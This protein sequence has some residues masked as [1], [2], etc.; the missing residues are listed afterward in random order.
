M[1]TKDDKTNQ[2]LR[3][4]I[5]SVKNYLHLARDQGLTT[6]DA[7][8]EVVDNSVDADARNVHVT[9]RKQDA[10]HFM[11]AVEDD[12][13][14]IPERIKDGDGEEW[15]GIAYC[16]SLGGRGPK[17][18]QTTIGKF[19]A[20]LTNAACCQSIVTEIYT[21]TAS[22]NRTRYN[23]MDLNRMEETDDLRM[24][25]ME[26]RE[27]P[28]H[29]TTH[30][31]AHRTGTLVV[32]AKVDNPDYKTESKLIS[33]IEEH[34]ALVYFKFIN[35]GTKIFVNGKELAPYDPTWRTPGGWDTYDQDKEPEGLPKKLPLVREPLV[36]ERI[37]IDD[38]QGKKYPVRV[39]LVQ[40]DVRKI[41]SFSAEHVKNHNKFMAEHG[42]NEENQGFYVMRNNRII[43]T[44][45][46]LGLFTRN[47]DHNY[48]RGIIEFPDELDKRFGVQVTKGR[49]HLKEPVQD[50]LRTVL[51]KEVGRVKKQTR[52]IIEDVVG[53]AKAREAEKGPTP[54]EA[55]AAAAEQL[56]KKP[57]AAH[58][59]QLE[60]QEEVL[61]AKTEE[62]QAIEANP[63]LSGKEKAE[64]VAPIQVEIQKASVPVTVKFKVLGSGAFYEAETWGKQV[65]VYIN[66]EHPF[67]KVYERATQKPE[68][69]ALLD[70]L[71]MSA[72]HAEK[73]Y[74]DPKMAN[75]IEQFRKEW[76]NSLSILLK[77]GEQ[78]MVD[79]APDLPSETQ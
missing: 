19:G 36:D 33:V 38:G 48:M 64:R 9:V 55:A 62:L 79:F 65:R 6:V 74:D 15:E 60:E 16:L 56:L 23:V 39:V 63:N 73:L 14:G 69:K 49:F 29:L 44:A 26:Y 58:P 17:A 11:I 46:T 37:E 13:T 57:K 10:G 4:Q 59:G 20:G 68:H 3:P 53:K 1:T 18:S 51:G 52:S 47:A 28:P 61:Q 50:A 41:R 66:A 12:G 27:P 40:Q 54:A 8:E 43:G 75:A 25:P 42:L 34:L 24:P 31:A 21:K 22:D 32:F 2:P 5:V 70:V 77:A 35:A 67:F 7:V 45:Q 76:S 71:L 72:A 78:A 30:W